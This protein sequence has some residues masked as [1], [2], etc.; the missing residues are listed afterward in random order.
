[1]AARYVLTGAPGSGKTAIL[2]AL[3]RRGFDVVG[4]AATDVIALQQAEGDDT[5]WARPAFIDDIVTMQRNRQVEA[6]RRPSA[7]QVFDRSPVCTLALCHYLGY[8]ISAELSA[9]LDR[10]TSDNIYD[11]RVFFVRDIG[12]CEPT[13]ARRITFDDSLD[14][15]RVHAE[16]YRTLGYDLV[17]IPAGPVADRTSLIEAHLTSWS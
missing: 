6:A 2:H 15:G 4:E 12:F 1:M 16:T 11:R 14:F 10:I 7:V 3:Q 5:P 17:D 9:E 13:A 8:P